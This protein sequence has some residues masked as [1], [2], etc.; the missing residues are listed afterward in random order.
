MAKKVYR[1]QIIDRV[2][3]S[4]W[5]SGDAAIAN[6]DRVSV[7]FSWIKVSLSGHNLRAESSTA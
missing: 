5:V 3:E 2:N 6:E 4:Q 7:F 1:W